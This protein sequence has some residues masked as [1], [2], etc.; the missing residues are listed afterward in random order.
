MVS[1]QPRSTDRRK[2]VYYVAATVDGFIAG[3]NGENDFFGSP[4]D[5]TQWVRD[6]LPEA[7]PARLR[8]AG[9]L[10]KRFDCVLIGRNTWQ[11][12]ASAGVP[13]PYPHLT[14]YVF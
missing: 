13:A 1:T 8:E 2:L 11:I 6:H 5:L 12:A 9:A 4:E 3:P 14:Q 10:A 7:L